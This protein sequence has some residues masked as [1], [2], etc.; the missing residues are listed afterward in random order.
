MKKK[1][2]I[3]LALFAGVALTAGLVYL[4]TSNKRSGMKNVIFKG[5]R[6]F[7]ELRGFAKGLQCKKE[8]EEAVS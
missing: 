4:F 7:E 5:G 2:K 6:K 8:K 3:A 1:E